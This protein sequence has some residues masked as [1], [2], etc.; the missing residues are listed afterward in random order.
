LAKSTLKADLQVPARE[1][2]DGSR[3]N[4]SRSPT[5]YF[6]TNAVLNPAELL[7]VTVTARAAISSAD[8]ERHDDHGMPDRATSLKQILQMPATFHF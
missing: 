2:A 7:L 5:K 8:I 1:A 6:S 4:H 3:P